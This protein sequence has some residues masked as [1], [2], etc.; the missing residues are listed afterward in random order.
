MH[1]IAAM[2]DETDQ[3][4]YSDAADPDPV[5][6][7]D[8]D[9]VPSGSLSAALDPRQKIYRDPFNE[10]VVFVV[11]ALGASIIAPV[12]LL[13]VKAFSSELDEIP[14]IAICIGIELI[15]IFGLARPAMKPAE[16]V[17]W[18]LLWAFSAGVLGAAFWS[19]VYTQL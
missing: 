10:L 3:G 5:G 6:P 19:L 2:A 18:A 17:L 7:G 15:L 16:R 9:V 14:F 11:S 12:I 4:D 1:K 13:I 8:R